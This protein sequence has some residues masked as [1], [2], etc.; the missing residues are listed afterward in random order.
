MK[1]KYK[2]FFLVVHLHSVLFSLK[3]LARLN[4]LD[5]HHATLRKFKVETSGSSLVLVKTISINAPVLAGIRLEG[6]GAIV[7]FKSVGVL[8]GL[9]A[10]DTTRSSLVANESVLT[11]EEDGWAV[12]QG[13][14]EEGSLTGAIAV[15][16]ER[17][18]GLDSNVLSIGSNDLGLGAMVLQSKL[19]GL[20]RVGGNDGTRSVDS[21]KLLVVGEDVCLVVSGDFKLEALHVGNVRLVG[22]D[23]F[24]AAD[25]EDLATVV[26]DDKLRLT[27]LDG[28]E[29]ILGDLVSR[30]DLEHGLGTDAGEVV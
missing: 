9:V 14:S 27:V 7:A 11:T 1:K 18:T 6:V 19:S 30:L 17:A 20:S 23:F 26:G 24:R 25:R 16:H 29:L 10:F 21:G 5:Q 28:E 22:L 4:V 3:V 2:Q 15:G 12:V 8:L 13:Q